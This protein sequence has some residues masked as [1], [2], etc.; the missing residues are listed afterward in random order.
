[1]YRTTD[2]TPCHRA[3]VVGGGF[4]G[5]YAVWI[6][7]MAD[8]ILPLFPA[9]LSAAAARALEQL[10]LTPVPRH[11]VVDIDEDPCARLI[12]V[13]PRAPIAAPR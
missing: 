4:A 12:T 8:R 1:M 7:E 2:S 13:E 10:G 11:K 5:L 9:R 6:F 3:V